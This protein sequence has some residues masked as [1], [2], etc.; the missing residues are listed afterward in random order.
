V[1]AER[2]V[3]AGVVLAGG[4]SSRMGTSKAHLLW[5]GRPLV[6]HMVDTLLQAGCH[7]VYISG[8]I[9]GYVGIP[10]AEPGQGPAVAVATLLRRFAGRYERL[11]IVPVDMPL[12]TP[13]TLAVLL[14]A[15]GSAC[16]AD[17]PLPAVIKTSLDIPTPASL[18]GL[19]RAAGAGELVL[20]EAQRAEM[21]NANTPEQWEA[22]AP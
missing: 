13:A 2:A 14:G 10:D 17:L 9:D 7:D 4:R 21:I 18:R 22:L 1:V 19:L 5:R 12:L 6:A 20:A 8:Q 16:F 15:E 3:L 11:L